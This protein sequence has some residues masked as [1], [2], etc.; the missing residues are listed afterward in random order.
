VTGG[1]A[2]YGDAD[3]IGIAV[4]TDAGKIWWAKNNTWVEGDPSSGTTPSYT[5]NYL[6]SHLHI[7]A[8]PYDANG[9][10]TIR[11][12]SSEFTYSPPSG[13]SAAFD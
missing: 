1:Y 3:V 12:L 8:T 6:K 10:L 2:T 9:K 11:G 13:F 5:S 7:H 4:D